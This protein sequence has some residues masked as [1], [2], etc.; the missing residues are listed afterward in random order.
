MREAGI[1]RRS[2]LPAYVKVLQDSRDFPYNREQ[3]FFRTRV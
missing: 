1:A 2:Y 3:E